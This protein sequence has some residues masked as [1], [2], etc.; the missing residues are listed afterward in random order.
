MKTKDYG[1]AWINQQQRPICSVSK[2]VKGVNKG[3]FEVTMCRGR[4][5]DGTIKPGEKVIVS[6][7]SIISKPL[8][9]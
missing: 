6:E 5:P 4:N 7:N 3:K 2:I 8:E 1:M 9:E